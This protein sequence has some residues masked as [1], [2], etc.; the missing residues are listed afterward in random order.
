MCR[1][2]EYTMDINSI[3]ELVSIGVSVVA[4]L[5]AIIKRRKVKEYTVEELASK[6]NNKIKKYTDKQCAKNKITVADVASVNKVEE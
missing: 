6:V 5:I 2:G 3:V 1:G 4:L